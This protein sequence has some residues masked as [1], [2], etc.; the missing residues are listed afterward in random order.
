MQHGCFRTEEARPSRVFT[1]AFFLFWWAFYFV[2]FFFGW[3]FC[4]FFLMQKSILVCQE[5]RKSSKAQVLFLFRVKIWDYEHLVSED[6]PFSWQTKTANVCSKW[7]DIHIA[8]MKMAKGASIFLA[9]RW[10]Y[11]STRTVTVLYILFQFCDWSKFRFLR[12]N[13]GDRSQRFFFLQLM[14]NFSCICLGL[15]AVDPQGDCKVLRQ[16]LA[17]KR[18]LFPWKKAHSFDEY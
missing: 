6:I 14:L 3:L 5:C 9:L 12:R 8:L 11:R 7:N 4:F 17:S 13:L 16:M 1:W 18:S 10:Q 2:L 15:W